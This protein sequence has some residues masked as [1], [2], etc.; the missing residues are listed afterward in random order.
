V[1]RL[2]GA[3]TLL[4]ALEREV[5]QV[6]EGAKIPSESIEVIAAHKYCMR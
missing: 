1:E 5:L 2:S 3:S 6:C 4:E